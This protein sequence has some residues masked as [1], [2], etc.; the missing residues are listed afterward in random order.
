MNIKQITNTKHIK[1]INKETQCLNDTIKLFN[2]KHQ[3]ILS[4]TSILK[5]EN[6][7]FSRSFNFYLKEKSK[8]KQY[9]Q[10]IFNDILLEYIDKGYEVPDLNFNPKL[11]T[12]HPLT[13][14]K[15]QDIR[16]FYNSKKKPISF[17]KS[18]NYISK[19]LNTTKQIK[20]HQA[21]KRMEN[22]SMSI[23]NIALIKGLKKLINKNF[24]KENTQISKYNLK[25]RKIVLNEEEN[26]NLYSNNSRY[27]FNNMCPIEQDAL[28]PE[29]KRIISS[30]N[31]NINYNTYKE[32][33]RHI[34][35]PRKS[36]A[37][38]EVSKFTN[39]TNCYEN[40][41][42][43]TNN[44]NNNCYCYCNN[45]NNTTNYSNR[46]TNQNII[47][48][49]FSNN[50]RNSNNSNCNCN[51]DNNKYSNSASNEMIKAQK[52]LTETNLKRIKNIKEGN[53]TPKG[54]SSF[55]QIFKRNLQ[56]KSQ[57]NKIHRGSFIV[58]LTKIVRKKK[59]PIK[60]RLNELL[61]KIFSTEYHFDYPTF[62]K[63]YK[64]YLLEFKHMSQSDIE[65]LL[66]KKFVFEKEFLHYLKTLK[67]KIQDAGI[68]DS[69][70]NLFDIKNPLHSSYLKQ[71]KRQDRQINAFSANYIKSLYGQKMFMLKKKCVYDKKLIG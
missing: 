25:I 31:L 43:V 26:S 56:P 46:N 36:R 33:V 68:F 1:R 7:M 50:K 35:Q 22:P 5:K 41:S 39:S 37:A 15:P 12:N 67:T 66:C 27:S 4:E 47:H 38:F 16:E 10:N 3:K 28:E 32:E 6:K 65:N 44:S 63:D 60:E 70:K 69:C 45:N 51:C 34:T 23:I 48:F 71:I 42:N 13:S 17:D 24:E 54:T 40:I 64:D 58:R 19:L 2:L 61:K 8:K 9:T 21:P 30:N 11:F 53:S 14:K 59:L 29:T 52:H 62:M 20:L 49:T 57:T 55:S 18:K